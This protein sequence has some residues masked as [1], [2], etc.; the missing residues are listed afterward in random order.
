MHGFSFHFYNSSDLKFQVSNIPKSVGIFQFILLDH[1]L[2]WRVRL[3]PQKSQGQEISW[4]LPQTQQR[5]RLSVC[6]IEDLSQY[7]MTQVD[8]GKQSYLF[9]IYCQLQSLHEYRL[10]QSYQ[11]GHAAWNLCHVRN[12]RPNMVSTKDSLRLEILVYHWLMYVLLIMCLL[13]ASS[14]AIIASALD[15]CL[16]LTSSFP[17]FLSC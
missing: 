17:R 2:S 10:M 13:D 9:R 11:F 4:I 14:S 5:H 6:L 3:S 12:F 8:L 15:I 7:S 16:L 1:Q